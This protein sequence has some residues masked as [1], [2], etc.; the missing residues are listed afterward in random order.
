MARLAGCI[1]VSVLSTAVTHT[2]TAADT[3]PHV[4][5]FSAYGC[6]DASPATVSGTRHIGQVIKGTYTEWV[7]SY[8]LVDA[9]PRLL[10]MSLKRPTAH[11]LSAAEAQALLTDSLAIGVLSNGLNRRAATASASTYDVPENVPAEPVKRLAKPPASAPDLSAPQSSGVDTPPTAAMKIFTGD[12]SAVLKP[13]KESSLAT[14]EPALTK[15]VE[16]RTLVA[17]AQSFPWNT[18]AYLVMSYSDGSSWRCS[19]TVVSPYVVLTAGHCVHNKSRGGYVTSVRVYP[20]QNQANPGS[21]ASRPYGSNTSVAAIQA[22]SQWM[23]MSGNDSYPITDY[24]WDFAAIQFSTPFTYTGTFMPVIFGS[25]GAPVT[26][27]GY[28][29][30]VGGSTVYGLYNDTAPET[31][32]TY[33]S[34]NNTHIR[35]FS[36]DASGGNSGGPFIYTDPN[37]NQRYMVGTLSYGDDTN[38]A[39]GGPWYDPWNQTLISGWV[40]WTPNNNEVAQSVSGVRLAG[41]FSSAQANL[42]SYL[43]FYNDSAAAGS[44]DVTLADYITGAPLATW[45][46]PSLPPES[47]RQFSITEIENN[48]DRSFTKPMIYS[49]SVRPTFV[50]AVQNVLWN[51]SEGSLTNLST[52]DNP[53]GSRTALMNVHSSLMEAAYPSAVIVHSTS[54]SNLAL[55]LGIYDA[56]SGRKLGTYATGPIP[57]NGQIL[58]SMPAIEAAAAISPGSVF[59]Y[60]VRSESGGVETGFEGYLQLLLNNKNA[61]IVTDMTASCVLSP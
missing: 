57:P 23:Q 26:S 42:L 10:C 31:S 44:V 50:G 41:V 39:A 43:R 47:S 40:S 45:H 5:N 29:A 4:P 2:A 55:N 28:P 14:I 49:L 22:T 48:A 13:L 16:D 54:A 30:E 51:K 8:R 11:D 34:H 52:C 20:G 24:K 19:G 59:H 27:A 36:V 37:T 25:T 7:E 56:A 18:L 1:A 6:A 15:G 9:Q 21:N 33:G 38:D 53:A 60:N 58:M 32:R 46:S 35:E 17:N 61:N 12:A 3:T